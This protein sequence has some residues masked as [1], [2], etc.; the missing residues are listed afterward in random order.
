M[1]RRD[2]KPPYQAAPI[3]EAVIQF[4]FAEPLGASAFRK[5]CKRLG[6]RYATNLPSEVVHSKIDFAGRTA[7]FTGEPQ[8]RL[9]S[10][11]EA[12]VLILQNKTYTWSRLAPYQGW[13]KLAERV[14]AELEF[15]SAATGLRRLS[16]IGVMYINRL[17]IPPTGNEFRYEDYLQINISLPDKWR[18]VQNYAWRFERP[19][20]ERGLLAVVQSATA[21]PEVPGFGAII[22]DMDVIATGDL[23]FKIEDICVKLEDMRAL[24]NE[25]FETS[26]SDL[27]RESFSQ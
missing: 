8:V 6:Q 18:L 11:D 16:R 5:L 1:T 25:I 10:L 26:I 17:D 15:A 24:K 27:A 2:A 3:V 13:E 4:Q 22:L 20:T 14:R 23:P 9:S 7:A 21:E 19:F 12:D